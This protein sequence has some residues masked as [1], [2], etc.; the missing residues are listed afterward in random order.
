MQKLMLFVIFLAAVV[1]LAKRGS[2][3]MK[4]MGKGGGGCSHCG[5]GKKKADVD[6]TYTISKEK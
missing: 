5:C 2:L 6:A 1:F 4:S 3:Y